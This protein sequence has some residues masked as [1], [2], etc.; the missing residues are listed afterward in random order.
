MTQKQY[1]R[2]NSQPLADDVRKPENPSTYI[3]SQIPIATWLHALESSE[4]LLALEAKTSQRM[5]WCK[6][7][8]SRWK[9]AGYPDPKSW[10]E[11]QSSQCLNPSYSLNH[12]SWPNVES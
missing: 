5:I 11:I 12:A 7:V 3:E 1:E 6:G 10:P 9:E 4:F 2:A 8:L